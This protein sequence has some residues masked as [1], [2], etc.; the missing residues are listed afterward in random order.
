MFAVDFKRTERLSLAPQIKSYIA[1]SY[2]EDPD[3]YID[4]FRNLD[5]LRGDIVV[6]DVHS[7]SLNKLLNL[8]FEKACILF[9]IGAMYSQL[10][11]KTFWIYASAQRRL[12][13]Q[14][15]QSAGAFKTL[16]DQ[17]SNWNIGQA[18]DFQGSA[19][20][21][22]VDAM[23]AQAQECWWQKAV[24]GG[25]KDQAIARLASQ[26]ADY[27]ETAYQNATTAGNFTSGWLA[28]LQAKQHHFRAAAQFRKAADCLAAGKYG[29]EVA[30]LQA[31]AGHVKKGMESGLLKNVS[32]YMQTDLKN[33]QAAVQTSL[34]RAEK[35][36]D[37]VCE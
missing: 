27:Y 8:N 33:L 10:G 35:D 3:V 15:Q 21:A 13:F 5:T 7:A 16:Q 29:E 9:N 26:V 14:G 28:H 25:M 6:P 2:A 32:S 31:A 22:L 20:S 23:L 18:G 30:R 24:Q 36:N 12:L 34:Q 37:I 17:L 4:D 11:V 1:T 19:L